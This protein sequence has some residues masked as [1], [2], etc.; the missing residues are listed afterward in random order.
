MSFWRTAMLWPALLA[1]IQITDTAAQTLPVMG[2]VA[3]KNAD[4]KRL[5]V[6]KQGLAELGYVE[7]KNIRIEYR[8][9]VLDAEY[10]GV[11]AD[12][13]NRKVDMILA[14]NVAAT[15]AAAKASK[16]IPIVMLAVFDPVGIGVVK[17]VDRPGTNVTGTT[18]YAPQLIGE[19]LRM[20]KRIVPNLDKVAMA[21]NGNNA[22]NAPQFELLRSEAQKLG[23]EV[24]SLDIR[25][26]E[27]VDAAF[28]KA[29]AF[30]AKALVNAV[31]TFINSRRFA[32]AVRAAKFKLPA[33]YSDVEYV[34]AGG[35]MALGPGH[36]EGYYGAAKYVDKI[37]RGANPAD[38]PI[39]G[40]TE[41]TMSVNRA[42]LSTLGLS[43][44]SD[45]VAQVNQWID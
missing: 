27:D 40:P 3:A 4:P 17:S 6:F 13:V 29:L 42:A 9:A 5:D 41:F 21:L 26:P 14:A 28:D 37:L 11:M 1:V 45:L 12:L 33:V 15:V 34:L 23:I 22:N 10:Q 38:L 19:R 2:Y 43:L 18:M 32:L 39:A 25:K 7:E 44:P 36:Y 20:L 30:G 16:A 24:Q 35:L 31:D 8:E